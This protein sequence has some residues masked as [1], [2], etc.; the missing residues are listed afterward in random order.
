MIESISSTIVT[1]S[2]GNDFIFL[3]LYSLYIMITSN[4]ANYDMMYELDGT[5]EDGSKN[6]MEVSKSVYL[7]L[8][9]NLLA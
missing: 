5:I 4:D 3:L 9:M 7:L 6:L 2:R 8:N 1:Y